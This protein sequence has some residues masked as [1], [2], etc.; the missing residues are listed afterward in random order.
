MKAEKLSAIAHQQGLKG[1]VVK[2]VNK[3][4]DIVWKRATK[5]DLVI[6]AGSNFLIAELEI[7]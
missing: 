6:V 7:L 3:A 4:L 1:E 2:D 5:N